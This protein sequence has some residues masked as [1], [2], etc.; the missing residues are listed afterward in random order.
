MIPRELNVGAHF[1]RSVS[2]FPSLVSS[3]MHD[4]KQVHRECKADILFDFGWEE[5]REGTKNRSELNKSYYSNSIF[6]LFSKTSK[7]RN[8]NPDSG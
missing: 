5:K 1:S 2:S 4:A 8:P 6:H 3:F 7:I